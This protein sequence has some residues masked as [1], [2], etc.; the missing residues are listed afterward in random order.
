MKI[1]RLDKGGDFVEVADTSLPIR[2]TLADG[3]IF[4]IASEEDG[5]FLNLH[6]P[7]ND[8]EIIPKARNVVFIGG[9]L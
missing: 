7:F 8:L 3:T 2:L 5:I 4:E 6:S 9:V 1:A